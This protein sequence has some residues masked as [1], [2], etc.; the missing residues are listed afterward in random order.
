MLVFDIEQR[1]TKKAITSSGLAM[2]VNGLMMMT[3]EG[4]TLCGWVDE[5]N[6]KAHVLSITKDG[7]NYSIEH[8]ETQ[9]YSA[10][11]ED[12]EVKAEPP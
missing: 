8:I 3:R 1:K 2:S 9:S 11:S 10:S 4:K 12:E 5:F 7:E 6:T